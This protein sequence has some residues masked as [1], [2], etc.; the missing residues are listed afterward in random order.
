M[1][2]HSENRAYISHVLKQYV[3]PY[4]LHLGCGTNRFEGWINIDC[5]VNAFHADLIWD[6]TRGLPF[7]DKSCALIHSEHVLEH[8]SVED[9]LSLLRECRRVLMPGG[10][11]RVGMPS[12][13]VLMQQALDGSWR[14]TNAKIP[15]LQGIQTRCEAVNV[16]M[17]WWGH[18]WLYDREELHRRLFEAGFG[19]VRDVELGNSVVSELRGLESRPET[20]LICEALP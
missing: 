19:F 13:D 18:A 16:G 9:G 1:M 2:Y 11:M 20:F 4:K 15:E 6:L 12:L 7:E 14:A 5:D 8:F 3:A 17:R 10:V